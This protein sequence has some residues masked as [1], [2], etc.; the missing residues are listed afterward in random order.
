MARP[1]F[2]PT[3]EQ[4]KLLEAVWVAHEIL[5]LNRKKLWADAEAKRRFEDSDESLVRRKH[6]LNRL[7]REAQAS[8]IP[9][10]T[11][12]KDGL[13][14]AGTNKYYELTKED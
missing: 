7:L 11:I 6:A 2:T 4:T 9:V 3:P 10:T 13:G 5:E 14:L 12:S 8:G 1:A